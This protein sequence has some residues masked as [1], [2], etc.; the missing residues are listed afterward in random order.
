LVTVGGW[1]QEAFL[2]GMQADA[3][4]LAAGAHTIGVG[5]LR[6]PVGYGATMVEAHD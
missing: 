6:Q 3:R 5:G 4:Q 2:A 1:I